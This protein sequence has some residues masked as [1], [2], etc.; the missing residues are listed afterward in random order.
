MKQGIPEHVGNTTLKNVGTL[1]FYLYRITADNFS[2]N[3]WDM[4]DDQLTLNITIGGE[5]IFSGNLGGLRAENG[6][7]FDPVYSVAPGDM[8]DMEISVLMNAAAGNTYQGKN[9][10]CD[11]TVYATQEN[12][13]LN[14]EPNNVKV[15]FGPAQDANGNT[16]SP[17]FVVDGYNTASQVCFDWDWN[18]N[19]FWSEKYILDIKHETAD[20]TTNIV[21][22][23]VLIFPGERV[24]S[25][26]GISASDVSVDWDRDIVKINKS[27]F[28]ADWEGFEVKMSGLQ[29]NS[30]GTPKTIPYKYWSLNR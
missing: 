9:I 25:T 11:L 19:D 24:V 15:R 22:Y 13:P 4:L 28:P 29:N 17:T 26:D 6:G 8:L 23:R 14:G 20:P 2:G 18:P 27:A 7:Y 16:G 5:Q 30:L 3:G 10:T 1:P 21:E 12:T